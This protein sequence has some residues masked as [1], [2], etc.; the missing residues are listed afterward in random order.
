MKQIALHIQKCAGCRSIVEQYERIYQSAENEKRDHD[1]HEVSENAIVIMNKSMQSAFT[2]ITLYRSKVPIPTIRYSLFQ[3]VKHHPI[4]SSAF[5]FSAIIAMAVLTNLSLKVFNK[6]NNPT[7]IIA[8]KSLSRYEVI[9]KEGDILWTMITDEVHGPNSRVIKPNSNLLIVDL[10][11]DGKNEVLTTMEFSGYKNKKALRAFDGSKKLLFEIPEEIREFSFHFNKY[12][13]PFVPGRI[14]ILDSDNDGKKEIFVTLNN[15]RSPMILQHIDYNGKILGEY[16]HY[17]SVQPFIYEEHQ[18]G[19]AKLILYGTNDVD[20]DKKLPSGT[21]IVVDPTKM[22]GK[23]ESQM[24][25]GFGLPRSNAELHAVLIPPDIIGDLI[26]K[27]I[28]IEDLNNITDRE[29]VFFGRLLDNK[30]TIVSDYYYVFSNELRISRV[31]FGAAGLQTY[32]KLVNDGVLK[33]DDLMKYY[34][35]YAMKIQYWKGNN[36]SSLQNYDMNQ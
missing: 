8:N 22:I 24:T 12:N 1:T 5:M 29:I 35:D 27:N 10:D 7:D 34:T 30:G 32:N 26:G 31:Y 4:A 16:W 15:G 18:T 14:V 6:D 36:W 23:I 33:Y 21:I 11:G 28:T 25:P 20:D 2:S 17:G 3:F 9:N 19:T 13:S